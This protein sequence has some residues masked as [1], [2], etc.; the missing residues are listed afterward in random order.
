MGWK[1]LL[2]PQTTVPAGV[3]F[4]A[5]THDSRMSVDEIHPVLMP[6]TQKERTKF[7][8]LRS[9]PHKTSL[10]FRCQSQVLCFW[11]CLFCFCL[12][13]AAPTAYGSS[14]A[15]GR[16]R[17]GYS[18]QPIPQPQQHQIWATF[19]TYTTAHHKAGFTSHWAR[20]GIEPMSSW[21]LVG[22]IT[23]EPS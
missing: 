13:R 23:T 11:V 15:R 4:L 5:T 7:H 3:V 8:R 14:Q 17:A 20:P 21:V 2:G 16:I 12:F 6:S 1:G 18:C 9:Q 10:Y 22:L 19:L